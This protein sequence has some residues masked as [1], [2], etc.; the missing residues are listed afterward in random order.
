MA[1]WAS[2]KKKAREI[3]AAEQSEANKLEVK[4]YN[5]K[6]NNDDIFDDYSGPNAVETSEEYTAYKTANSFPAKPLLVNL[7]G[8]IDEDA[9][10]Y[11]QEDFCLMGCHPDDHA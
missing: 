4:G 2:D 10:L 9:D 7:A 11:E 3:K 6:M 5:F 1:K 8:E